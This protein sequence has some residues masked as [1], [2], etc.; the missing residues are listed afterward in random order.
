[1][2]HLALALGVLAFIVTTQVAS[3]FYDPNPGR[4]INRDPIGEQGGINGYTF[5]GNSPVTEIDSLGLAPLNPG[6]TTEKDRSCLAACVT[7]FDACMDA[8]TMASLGI[9]GAGGAAQG[10]NKTGTKPRGGVAG[11]GPSGGYTSR[12]RLR[13]WPCGRA[14]GRTPTVAV[15]LAAFA[16]SETIGW[17][18]CEAK[19]SGC[20]SGC[21]TKIYTCPPPGPPNLSKNTPPATICQP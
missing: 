13:G 12:T 3:A 10:Y 6:T 20:V 21:P 14:I 11:G 1:M 4:W 18:A 8:V 15:A 16:V 2:K 7:A 17:A 19:Y 9:G 5:I